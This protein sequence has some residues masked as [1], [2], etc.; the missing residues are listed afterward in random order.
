MHFE[1]KINFNHHVNEKT[2]TA[3]RGIQLI[4]QLDHGID[5]A[6]TINNT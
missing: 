1:E 5:E 2:A 6:V 3:N 4:H